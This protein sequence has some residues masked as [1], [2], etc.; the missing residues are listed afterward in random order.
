MTEFKIPSPEE[1]AEL[2]AENY[3]QNCEMGWWD[4]PR[5]A[6]ETLQLANTELCEATEGARKDL[7]DDHLTDHKMEDVELA[8]FLLRL[9]DHGE[10]HGLSLID[11]TS[12]HTIKQAESDFIELTPVERHGSLA[13]VLF[14]ALMPCFVND[15]DRDNQQTRE[16]ISKIYSHLCMLT[17]IAGKV[18][19]YNTLETVKKKMA[20][21]KTRAD[22]TR[23][24]RSAENGKK[25]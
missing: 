11:E 7:Y 13:Y 22:H 23:A 25:F 18:S 4:R 16:G 9:L 6:L 19:G 24:A 2:A 1:F 20:Y 5:T 3:K 10:H 12:C 8:D 14:H 15:W 17:I 21:N